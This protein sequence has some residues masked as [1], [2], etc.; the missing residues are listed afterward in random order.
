[1][2]EAG[3]L[4]RLHA[5][6]RQDRSMMQFNMYHH[7]TVDEH[8]IRTVEVLS[9]IDK[10]K[11]EE[12]HPL[13]NKIMPRSRIVRRSMSRCCCTTSPRPPGGSLRRRRQG[14]RKLCP[15]LGLSPSRRRWSS[16]SST[17]TF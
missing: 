11:A 1:M 7:Y 4:G 16:G 15:R 5:G 3:V 17:S 9:E 12:I 2:N 10:G 6:I 13:A 8:L 14:A